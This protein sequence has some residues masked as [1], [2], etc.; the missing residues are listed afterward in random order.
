MVLRSGAFGRLLCQ[1]DRDPMNRISIL[2]KETPEG[3]PALFPSYEDTMRKQ[4]SMN[5]ETRHHQE[6]NLPAP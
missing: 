4:P 6:P 5:Q 1:A 2:I 3:S